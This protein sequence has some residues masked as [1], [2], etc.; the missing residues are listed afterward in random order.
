MSDDDRLADYL[1]RMDNADY[2]RDLDD[3][4]SCGLSLAACNASK[5]VTSTACCTACSG[6]Q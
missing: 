6:H 2:R 5:Y 1:A 4:C 3:G